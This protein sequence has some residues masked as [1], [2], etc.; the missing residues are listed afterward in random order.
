MKKIHYAWVIC[1]A[2]LLLSMCNVGLTSNILTVYLPFIE[3]TGISGAQGSAI[4][5]VRCIFSFVSAFFITIYYKH[6]SIRTG[7]AVMTAIGAAGALISAFAGN[8]ILL[9]YVAAAFSGVAYSIGAIVPASMLIGRWFLRRKGLALGI[10]TAGSGIANII[11]T[12]LVTAMVLG[13]G[14][15]FS[16]AVQAF[17]M[18]AS[19]AL[20]FALTR[21][22]PSDMKLSM[23]GAEDIPGAAALSG[24]SSA[25]N[26]KSYHVK[27]N[28]S[29]LL[30]LMIFL[31]GGAGTAGANHLSIL[32]TSSGCTAQRAAAIVTV[33]SV[34][35]LAGKFI[36][37]LASDRFG[38]K[39]TTL[40]FILLAAAGCFTARYVNGTSLFRGFMFTVL[41]GTGYAVYNMGMPLWASELPSADG[42]EKTLERFQILYAAGGILIAVM[43]GFIADRT[44]EYRTA[45]LVFTMM[46]IVS[47]A[48]LLFA[49]RKKEQAQEENSPAAL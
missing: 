16:F 26:D 22:D 24:D 28:V 39:A 3:E 43:P 29:I 5:S 17:I 9:Y 46:L 4:N 21:E 35:L 45:Y 1:F 37:G 23:L 34:F 30:L 13:H 27:R 25:V 19:A 31:L 20:F 47:G 12:P 36:C 6:F 40:F 8:R 38:A 10:F 11:F 41:M 32:C 33:Y 48:I 14:L 18:F 44:G 7:A 2:C 15:K 49:Y 42:F